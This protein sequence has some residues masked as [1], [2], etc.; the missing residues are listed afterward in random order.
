MSG[1]D[2]L[3]G[4]KVNYVR[5]SYQIDINFIDGNGRENKY[6]NLQIETSFLLK[7]EDKNFD[8]ELDDINSLVPL[9][10]L[11]HLSVTSAAINNDKQLEITF[12]NQYT[13]TVFPKDKYEA[14][15]ITGEDFATLVGINS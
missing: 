6:T 4:A 2:D 5:F 14:W 1:I 7:H 11:L 10:R 12:D 15:S 8:I 3:V 13:L 9:I